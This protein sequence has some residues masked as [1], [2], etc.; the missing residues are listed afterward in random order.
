MLDGCKEQT[1]LTPENMVF[2]GCPVANGR[3]RGVVSEPELSVSLGAAGA[4]GRARGL[5]GLRGL[6]GRR[7]PGCTGL[8]FTSCGVLVLRFYF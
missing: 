5:E 6:E 3:C 1:K 2:S 4:S 8:G 7:D